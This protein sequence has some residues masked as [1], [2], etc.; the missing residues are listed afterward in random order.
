MK[1]IIFELEYICVHNFELKKKCNHAN[2]SIITAH[3][4]FEKIGTYGAIPK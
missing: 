1:R 4:L 3:H 2:G